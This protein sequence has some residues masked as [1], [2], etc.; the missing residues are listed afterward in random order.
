[1]ILGPVANG[2]EGAQQVDLISVKEKFRK[3]GYATR[4]YDAVID[5]VEGEG[6]QLYTSQL[7]IDHGDDLVMSLEKKG[8]INAKDNIPVEFAVESDRITPHRRISKPVPPAPLIEPQG[9]DPELADQRQNVGKW[10]KDGNN[11]WDPTDKRFVNPKPT[12]TPKPPVENE[13][14]TLFGK[15]EDPLVN[16]TLLEDHTQPITLDEPEVVSTDSG[17]KTPTNDPPPAAK[18]QATKTDT[19][20][21]EESPIIVERPEAP[22]A[23]AAKTPPPAAKGVDKPTRINVKTM[24]S[25]A[26]DAIKGIKKAPLKTAG[27]V[28][29]VAAVGIGLAALTSRRRE[30]ERRKRHGKSVNSMASQMHRWS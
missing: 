28:A 4:M 21:I 1:M 16:E 30:R 7:A 3:Q 20:K 24:S 2:P 25:A 13:F 8:Y 27:I 29:G 14:E 26:E 11:L 22:E 23:P 15:K 5:K 6:G 18:Q 17:D 9:I 10:D 12:A 19:P